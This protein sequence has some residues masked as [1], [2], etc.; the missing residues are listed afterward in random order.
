MDPRSY[1]ASSPYCQAIQKNLL[2]V[3]VSLQ[4]ADVRQ[5]VALVTIQQIDQLE[6]LYSEEELLERATAVCRQVPFQTVVTVLPA[7]RQE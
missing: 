4:I 7:K 5:G 3:G 2:E 1:I 6:Y